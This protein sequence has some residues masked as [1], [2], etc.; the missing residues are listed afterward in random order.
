MERK[1]YISFLFICL[2]S[3]HIW[4]THIDKAIE[5]RR[6]YVKKKQRE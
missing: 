5:G 1:W 4:E 2:I 3:L 6:Q